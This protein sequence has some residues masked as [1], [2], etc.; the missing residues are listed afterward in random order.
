M[1][2][3][4]T[5]QFQRIVI[6]KVSPEIDGGKF[7]IKRIVSEKVVVRATV[8]IDGHDEVCATLLFR[9]Q[10][11]TDWREVR[12]KSLGNDQWIGSF[13][14]E[15]EKNY[16]YSI[17]GYIQEF[18]SWRN[19]L[20]KRIEAKQDVT[21]DLQI[22]ARLIQER[23][24]CCSKPEEV[25]LRKWAKKL[26]GQIST[27]EA[28]TLVMNQELQEI[29]D[30]HLNRDKRTLYGKEL[31][32]IVESKLAQFSSW[33]EFFPRSW[34]SQPGKH[35]TFKDCERILP[36]IARMGF[37]VVYLPPIHPIGITYRK[38]KNNSSEYNP[39]DPGS[40]WAIGSKEGG[41]KSV[42]PQLGSLEDFQRFVKKANGHGLS[43]ALDIAFQCS[44]DHPYLKEHPDWFKWRPD[45][46]VQYAENPPKKY[47]DV[48]PLNF[49]TA[50]SKN[51]YE[52]LKNI[53]LFWV[54]QG[55]KIF[56]V[57]NPHTKPFYFWDWLIAEVKKTC[58]DVI[59]LA[60][61][62]TR[63]NVMFRLAKGGFSQ[64]YTY[65][66]WRNTKKEFEDYLT[67]ITST[68]VADY[69]RPNLWPNTPDILPEHLQYGGRPAFILRAVLAATLSSNFGIYGPAF[70]LCVSDA[71]AEKEE[72]L[73]SEKYE[74]KSWDW[75][76]QG[77]LKDVLARLNKIR[78]EN[79]CLQLTRNIRFCT[80]DN[81]NLLAFYK[82]TGDYS[83]IIIVVVN[84]DPHHTQV[85]W[86]QI[87]KDELG[88][89]KN[90]PYLAH[91]LLSDD[92]Y[93]WQGDK[94]Y[95]ELNPQRSPA[96]II[97]VKKHLRREED[98]DYFL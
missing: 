97:L 34:G 79:P 35:G 55:V 42:H 13:A 64:S 96:H 61:A 76:K 62:F 58:P 43:V 7:P 47:Q 50:D 14:I 57:D 87:P 53:V 95:I 78:K 38:G 68:E 19:D 90:R 5:P 94:S 41:H 2:N 28:L 32:V 23:A 26:V 17:C 48:L 60:E 11:E 93:I 3:T 25:K 20:K 33:Y 36:E 77:H 82:A 52:E 12:M 84:L 72:Y 40:P 46:T 1:P 37:N 6:E 98:F 66:T 29:L 45:G 30:A 24:E 27:E 73:D 59:F 18:S 22:G 70:E 80:V 63:P 71:L 9:R 4:H 21:I 83:N 39:K 51:L 85:G 15:E 86:L 75:N 56:R 81:E 89:E 31:L 10:D 65:F 88:L 54:K 49:E 91:D 74:I 16:L 92:K 44:P 8:F 69:F 67:E